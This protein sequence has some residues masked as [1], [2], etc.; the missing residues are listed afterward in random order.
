M[1]YAIFLCV[2]H[3]SPNFHHHDIIARRCTLARQGTSLAFSAKA[4]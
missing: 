3:S 4:L 2:P 1:K